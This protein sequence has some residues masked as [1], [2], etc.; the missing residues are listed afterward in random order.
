MEAT[1]TPL[2]RYNAL[3][4]LTTACSMVGI[5]PG[6]AELI[7]LGENAVF[8]LLS[9]SVVARVARDVGR[10]PA[11]ERE[12]RVAHWLAAESI[13]AVRALDVPQPI[14][15][16]GR[17]VTLWASVSDETEYGTTVELADLLQRLHTA[18]IPADL[19]LP[20]LAPFDRARSRI[21]KI[22][23]L[24]KEDRQFLY[25]R[26]DE[27]ATEYGR[28]SFTL[29]IGAIHGDA[30]V[31][32]VFRDRH[33]RALLGDLD[34]F[35]HGPREWDLVLTAL[36]YDRYG[37]HTEDEYEAFVQGYGYDVMEWPGYQVL[38]DVREF[39][40]VTWLAQNV[41]KVPGVEMELA[42]R[43][44]ALRSGG[45]RRDWNPF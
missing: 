36:Y 25:D 17:V 32:N 4:A 16:E 10:L 5:D 41:G 38:G 33:G 2:D 14:V 3:R 35:A 20:A 37:W 22:S 40:M 15:A 29:P 44:T 27:L 28:L 31:G 45:S 6:D 12:I 8:R 23:T 34:G 21:R 30:S 39:L 42:K 9:S 19:K 11:S 24:S 26:C 1:L 7:R 18:S 43:L 13:P